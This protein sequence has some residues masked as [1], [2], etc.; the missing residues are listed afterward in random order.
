MRKLFVAV[1]TIISLNVGAQGVWEWN[2]SANVGAMVAIDSVFQPKFLPPVALGGLVWSCT[3]DAEALNANT[4][5][6]EIGGA[7]QFMVDSKRPAGYPQQKWYK[8]QALPDDAN[9][10]PYTLSKAT[11]VDTIRN[12]GLTDI[13]YIQSF[14]RTTLNF[15]IPLIRITKGTV[16]AGY[17]RWY[18]KFYK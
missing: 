13:T 11:M 16:S 12:E 1:A 3:V 5:K 8:F 9:S 4:A 7:N 17:V 2:D 15:D 10:F 14:T 6:V 18:F